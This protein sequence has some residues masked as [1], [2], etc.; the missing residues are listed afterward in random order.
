M[1]E[2]WPIRHSIR[3]RG[4]DYAEEGAYFVTF[5]T[6]DRHHLFGEVEEGK[7]NLNG[8]GSMVSK[9]W[10]ELPVK[11]SNLEMDIFTVM[12]NHLHGIIWIVGAGS[13]RPPSPQTPDLPSPQT[14]DL[15]SPQT[16][17][18]PSP[19]TPDPPINMRAGADMKMRA[20]AV[21]A[22]LRITLG[23]I[24]G[25]FKY[26]TTKSINLCWGT[27][28]YPVWQRNYYDRIIRNEFELNAIRR[29]IL[30]NPQRWHEDEYCQL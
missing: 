1:E 28:G 15:P 2:T 10:N 9:Q 13:P 17:D 22:P 19:Q 14:P 26:Q 5:C 23:K 11:F 12:P 24:V 6:Q 30:E 8:F 20:G 29:Y 25:Y 18:L 7:M 16:P 4:Y 27:P 21:T 3:Y